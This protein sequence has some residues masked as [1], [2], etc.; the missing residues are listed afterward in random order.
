MRSHTN[1]P[2]RPY[3]QSPRDTGVGQ[4]HIYNQGEVY[5]GPARRNELLENEERNKRKIQAGKNSDMERRI[6]KT[7][8]ELEAELIRT[9]KRLKDQSGY[10]DTTTFKRAALEVFRD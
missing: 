3:K 5:R 6:N 1:N 2:R 9:R 7:I 4:V 10:N 8:A